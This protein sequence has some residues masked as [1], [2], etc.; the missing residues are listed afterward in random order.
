MAVHHITATSLKKKSYFQ[1]KI[2]KN[3]NNSKELWKAPK[4]LGMKSGKVNQSKMLVLEDFYKV[5]SRT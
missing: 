3:P 1:E 2:E 4:S 5:A